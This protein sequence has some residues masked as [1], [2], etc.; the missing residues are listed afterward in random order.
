MIIVI[1]IIIGRSRVYICWGNNGRRLLY[2]ILCS[3]A[4]DPIASARVQYLP[5]RIRRS[6]TKCV[7]GEERLKLFDVARTLCL[8]VPPVNLVIIEYFFFFYRNVYIFYF[9]LSTLNNI[10]IHRYN[11]KYVKNPLNKLP[12]GRGVIFASLFRQLTR[13]Y[14]RFVVL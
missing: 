3:R 4:T 2:K 8:N 13:V 1:K 9:V 12:R 11:Y 7:W 14:I 6:M 10:S 5:L